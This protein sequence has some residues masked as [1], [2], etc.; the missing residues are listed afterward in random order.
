MDRLLLARL[1]IQRVSRGNESV[2]SVPRL[3]EDVDRHPAPTAEHLG[4]LCLR[5]IVRDPIFSPKLKEQARL[6]G[7]LLDPQHLLEAH[8]L[9]PQCKA[10]EQWAERENTWPPNLPALGD[11]LS[12]C[13]LIE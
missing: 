4:L 10:Q 6:L 5:A 2:I 3:E 9:P 8:T 13:M 11:A 12:S 1:T 7:S